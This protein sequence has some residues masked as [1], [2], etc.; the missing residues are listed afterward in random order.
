MAVCCLVNDFKLFIFDKGD[1]VVLCQIVWAGQDFVNELNIC[2][3][4]IDF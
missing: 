2:E 4:L 1:A 3:L